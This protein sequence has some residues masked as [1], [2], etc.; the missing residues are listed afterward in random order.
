MHLLFKALKLL[1]SRLGSAL[2]DVAILGDGP[3]RASLEAQARRLED[4]VLAHFMS[5]RFDR[6]NGRRVHMHSLCGLRHADFN[7]P[8]VWSYELYLRTCLALGLGMDEL[9]E[10]YRRMVFNVMARNQDDHTKNF[11]FLYGENDQDWRLAPA[12][13]VTYAHGTGW[14]ATHQ[15]SV[16]GNFEGIKRSDLDTVADEF[17]IRRHEEI[18]GEMSQALAQWPGIARAAGLGQEV[19][20]RVAQDHMLMR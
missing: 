2:P 6:E 14:T 20:R 12:F 8:R 19:I 1:Q 11:A 10:A 16:N 7:E 18:I 3:E 13:D 15:M 5:R 17:G 9:T 4:G